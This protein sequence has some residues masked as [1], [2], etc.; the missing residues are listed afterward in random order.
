MT[1]NNTE[2][3][4]NYEDVMKNMFPNVWKERKEREARKQK[5]EEYEEDVK[6]MKQTNWYKKLKTPS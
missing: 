6:K 4:E 1:K 2:V 5:V 3:F